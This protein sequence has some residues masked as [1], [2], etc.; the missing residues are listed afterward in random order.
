MSGKVVE[1]TTFSV[2]ITTEVIFSSENVTSSTL[3]Y[4]FFEIR[5]Q[6][7]IKQNIFWGM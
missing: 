3:Q 2:A 6:V 7:F 1:S 5:A 4:K